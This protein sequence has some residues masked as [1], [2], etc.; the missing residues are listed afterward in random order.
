MLVTWEWTDGKSWNKY[1]PELAGKIEAAF[2]AKR[3]R[4]NVDD[5][6]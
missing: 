4:V 6:R 5:E 2:A 1:E 3:S